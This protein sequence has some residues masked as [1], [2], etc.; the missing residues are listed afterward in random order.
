MIAENIRKIREKIAEAAAK[1]NRSADSIKLVAVSKR[2]P[3]TT[4]N[5]AYEAGQLLFGENYIQEVQSKKE[6]VP[7]SVIF[8]FIGHLQ[9][10][11]AK[12]AAATC[13]MIETVDTIKLARALDNHLQTLGKTMDI[14]VQ[15][16]IGQEPQK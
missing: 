4:I 5:E 13:S 7:P 12:I 2:F 10:N 9:S 6:L 15:V 8:H 16:N 11:K 14:L 3:A 1:A